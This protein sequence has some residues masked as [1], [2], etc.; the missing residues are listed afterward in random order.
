VFQCQNWCDEH[1]LP[2]DLIELDRGGFAW[3]RLSWYGWPG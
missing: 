1:K 2:W 3:I